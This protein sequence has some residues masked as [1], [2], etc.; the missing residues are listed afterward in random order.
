MIWAR[1][2]QWTGTDKNDASQLLEWGKSTNIFYSYYDI[3]GDH[4]SDSTA[5]TNDD[6][7]MYYGTTMIMFGGK[8]MAIFIADL[9]GD[10][11]PFHC[12]FHYRKLFYKL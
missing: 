4:W 12:L 3:I 9:D 1:T 2:K 7:T 11:Y 10:M 5:I 6:H 8:A